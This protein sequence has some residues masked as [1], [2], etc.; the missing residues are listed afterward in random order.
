[1][2]TFNSAITRREPLIF[3]ASLHYFT[4]ELEPGCT[5]GPNR[6]PIAFLL[7]Y[8]SS[9]QLLQL[10]AKPNQSKYHDARM[11]NGETSPCKEP[12]QKTSLPVL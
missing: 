6:L 12:K 10:G 9:S 8:S 7:V 1:M 4:L 5:L 3:Y 11:K 2:A